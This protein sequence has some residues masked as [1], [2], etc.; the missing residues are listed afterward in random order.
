MRIHTL[1]VLLM[2][3]VM[4]FAQGFKVKSFKISK[5]DDLAAIS[6]RTD[7]QGRTCGLVK[8][9]SKLND[10]EFS[11]AVGKVTRSVDEY[12]VYLPDGAESFS[13]SRPHYLPTTVRFPDFNVSCIIS[14]TTYAMEVKEAALEMEKCGVTLLV[15]PATTQVKV[16]GVDLR[17]DPLGEYQLLLPKG[18]HQCEFSAYG[19]RSA[20]RPVTTGRGM[21]RVEMELESIL[22]DVIIFSRTEGAEILVNGEMRATGRWEG[23]MLPAT[24]TV[25]QR[26]KGYLPSKQTLTLTEKEHRTLDLGELEHIKGTLRVTTQPAGCVLWIDGN[27]CG[28]APGDVPDII[29]GKH[30]LTAEMDTC[31]IQRKKEVSVRI[32]EAGIQDITVK[33][34]SDEELNRHAEALAIFRRA[35]ALDGKGESTKGY[36]PQHTAKAPFDSIMNMMEQLDSTFFVHKEYFPEYEADP[37]I[38]PSQCIGDRMFMFY[39]YVDIT[40]DEPIKLKGN[41]KYT[42]V[43]QPDKATRI[44]QKMGKELTRHEQAFLAICFYKNGNYEQAIQWF[45]KWHETGLSLGEENDYYAGRCYFMLGDACKKLGRST[46][47]KDW[48]EQALTI[49]EQTE[50]NQARL[51]K[52]RLAAK[53]G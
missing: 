36:M 30:T 42:Y 20:S 26:L 49:L 34:A 2:I 8:V 32:E 27:G 41:V 43:K 23:K 51:K 21:E 15:K 25:E 16:D 37:I 46:E 13:I 29:Y 31:G 28:Q 38:S 53:E 3:S 35:M 4:T 9:T 11:D 39:S 6:P 48:Q 50:K 5:S 47:G 12:W 19:C 45:Q 18:E 24:Y 14:K 7:R 44:A 40:E 22:A 33:V 1:F 10:L 52:F 17:C